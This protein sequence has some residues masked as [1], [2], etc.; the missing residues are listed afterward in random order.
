[1]APAN[2]PSSSAAAPAAAALALALLLAAAD[3]SYGS[4]QN[5]AD[6]KNTPYGTVAPAK[7]TCYATGERAQGAP[8]Y[9][10][11]PYLPC[12]NSTDTQ[13][14]KYG[15]W[16]KFCSPAATS[17]PGGGADCYKRGERAVEGDG[18]PVSPS[19]PCCEV[20]DL[21]LK[22][23]GDVGLF[24]TDP[25]NIPGKFTGGKCYGTNKRAEGAPGHPDIEKKPCCRATDVLQGREGP[26]NWGKFCTEVIATDNCYN[27]GELAE[28]APGDVPVPVKPCCHANDYITEAVDLGPGKYCYPKTTLGEP[29][30]GD[31]ECDDTEGIFPGQFYPGLCVDSFGDKNFTCVREVVCRPHCSSNIFNEGER[32]DGAD[33]CK[34]GLKCVDSTPNRPESISKCVKA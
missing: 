12:C 31:D 30:G 15:D 17:P 21:K 24:C 7:K 29:C 9:E 11:V 8:G 23:P 6:G 19:K 26:V 14:P 16:G 2:M 1:V 22:K 32:C 34:D 10:A 13:E 18:Q 4:D 5:C 3:A 33:S 28:A 27:Q 25:N 20:T